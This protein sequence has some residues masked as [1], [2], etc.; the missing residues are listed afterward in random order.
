MELTVGDRIV[1]LSVLPTAGT[2]LTMKV[3]RQLRDSLEFSETELAECGLKQ[4]GQHFEW[5]H[6]RV[7][8]IPIGEVARGIVADALRSMP[9][10][11]VV[12]D[13]QYALYRYFVEECQSE[14]CEDTAAKDP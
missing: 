6:D 12:T 14:D 5:Q 8:D 1:L 7:V 3:V 10:W 2:F 11:E 4:N 13:R 9:E